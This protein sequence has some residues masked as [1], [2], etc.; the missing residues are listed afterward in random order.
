[1]CTP[2]SLSICRFST[3]R[4]EH[5]RIVY[6]QEQCSDIT[7]ISLD[8]SVSLGVLHTAYIT[9]PFFQLTF[10]IFHT[11]Y[12]AEKGETFVKAI[13]SIK[14][15]TNFCVNTCT[16]VKNL[17]SRTIRNIDQSFYRIYDAFYEQ[18]QNLPKL[19]LIFLHIIPNYSKPIFFTN[20]S[21][22]T[23]N[24]RHPPKTTFYSPITKIN[25][26]KKHQQHDEDNKQA[27]A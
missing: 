20:Q 6:E 9:S 3:F 17:C 2:F 24:V 8:R 14:Q 27:Y 5:Q 22:T 16:H 7:Q 25:N 19:C 4:S 1:M 26:H 18:K 10:V 13:K 12:V 15:K 11:L 21:K 23:C